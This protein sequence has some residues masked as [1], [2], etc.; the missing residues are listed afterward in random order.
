MLI[1]VINSRKSA[2]RF[3][4]FLRASFFY[5]SSSVISVTA[6]V[7]GIHRTPFVSIKYHVSSLTDG[8][9]MEHTTLTADAK[10]QSPQ[11][12]TVGLAEKVDTVV[13]CRFGW[14]SSYPV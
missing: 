1:A 3:G 10:I 6:A 14:P 9:S 2:K 13:E 12:G 4:C 8:S 11:F 5:H 7:R